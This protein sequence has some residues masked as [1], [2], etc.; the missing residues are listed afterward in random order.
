MLKLE[1][2]RD[3][4]EKAIATHPNQKLLYLMYAM[5]EE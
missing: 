2:T 3:L 5:Y 1:R 4:F